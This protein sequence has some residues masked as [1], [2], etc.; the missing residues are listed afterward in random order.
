MALLLQCLRDLRTRSGDLDLLPPQV[1]GD[2]LAVSRVPRNGGELG[3][4]ASRSEIDEACAVSGGHTR[5]TAWEAHRQRSRSFALEPSSVAIGS[6][7]ERAAE[8]R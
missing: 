3:D 8:C 7:F 4:A 1:R 5:Q 2:S 6:P